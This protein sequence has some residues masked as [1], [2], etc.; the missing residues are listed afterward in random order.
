MQFLDDRDVGLASG[1]TDKDVHRVAIERSAQLLLRS[2]PLVALAFENEHRDI[3][4]KIGANGLQ[5]LDD[6]RRYR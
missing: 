1:V 5:M 2:L 3:F 6:L 4:D